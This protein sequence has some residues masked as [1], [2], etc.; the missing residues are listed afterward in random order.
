MS[1]QRYIENG[2]DNIIDF[3][4]LGTTDKKSKLKMAVKNNRRSRFRHSERKN[5]DITKTNNRYQEIDKKGRP[6]YI[7]I[8]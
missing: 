6:N 3:K 5:F 7:P 1:I 8:V 2:I 4:S